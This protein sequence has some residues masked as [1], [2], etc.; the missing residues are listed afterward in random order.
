MIKITQLWGKTFKTCSFSDSRIQSLNPAIHASVGL[1]SILLIGYH[2]ND[3]TCRRLFC[4]I[5]CYLALIRWY[6]IGQIF[7]NKG[8]SII[9]ICQKSACLVSLESTHFPL[10]PCYYLGSGWQH[11]ST[12]YPV[13][14]VS[15]LCSPSAFNS[16][17]VQQ[18]CFSKMQTWPATSI[19]REK[20]FKTGKRLCQPLMLSFFNHSPQLML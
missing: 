13:L 19:T 6:K 8:K 1:R 5:V 9:S 3:S 18:M 10:S 4:I 17:L 7:S 20:M 16:I 12:E 14:A 11:F 2:V 15:L